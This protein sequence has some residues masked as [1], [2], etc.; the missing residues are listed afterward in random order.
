MKMNSTHDEIKKLTE[1]MYRGMIHEAVNDE[2]LK[3]FL[4]EHIACRSHNKGNCQDE[5]CLA[6]IPVVIEH[7]EKNVLLYDKEG[8][9]ESI[10]GLLAKACGLIFIAM[11]E[12]S[13]A[14]KD[15]KKTF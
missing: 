1:D 10:I 7:L 5:E 4:W 15:R 13:D 12:E 14:R 3:K 8:V 6:G 9:Y 2:D 11:M